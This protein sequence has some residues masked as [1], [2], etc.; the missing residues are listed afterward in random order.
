MTHSPSTSL[1]GKNC[2]SEMA[3]VIFQLWD[4]GGAPLRGGTNG[5]FHHGKMHVGF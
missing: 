2:S 4:D 3:R 1:T 5:E